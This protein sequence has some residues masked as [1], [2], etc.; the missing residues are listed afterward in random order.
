MHTGV[1]IATDSGCLGNG[2]LLVNWTL[3]FPKSFHHYAAHMDCQFS[4]KQNARGILKYSDCVVY[5]F[6]FIDEDI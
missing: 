6:H 1:Y 4:N 3:C 5:C 2:G